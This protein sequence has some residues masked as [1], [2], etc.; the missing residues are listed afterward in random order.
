MS[1]YDI[2]FLLSMSATIISAASVGAAAMY[3]YLKG[4]GRIIPKSECNYVDEDE[5][6]I[7]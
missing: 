4:E 3:A 7:I 2:K 1:M 5:E 6:N